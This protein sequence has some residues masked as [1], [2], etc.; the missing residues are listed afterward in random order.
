M[1][2]GEDFN[3]FLY[4]VFAAVLHLG[5]VEF[6]KDPNGAEERG[7][8]P[9]DMDIINLVAEV[10]QVDPGDLKEGLT[11]RSCFVLPFFCFYKKK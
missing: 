8:M 6:T 1:K 10:L 11:H 5:N 7:V 3:D 9:K 4:R 2:F